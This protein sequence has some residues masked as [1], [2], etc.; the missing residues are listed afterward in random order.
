MLLSEQQQKLSG[1]RSL[2]IKVN[3]GFCSGCAG[4]T[5]S[6]S[7]GSCSSRLT[8]ADAQS[9]ADSLRARS[10]NERCAHSIHDHLRNRLSCVCLA[11]NKRCN[12]HCQ[13]KETRAVALTDRV[14]LDGTR[15]SYKDPHSVCVRGECEVGG[16]P[17]SQCDSSRCSGEINETF[18]PSGHRKWAAMV[19]SAPRSRRINVEY[20]E[21][22]TPAAKPSRTPS[23]G[24]PRSKVGLDD[25]ALN[26]APNTSAVL[27]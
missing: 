5:A 23:H 20:V 7:G 9:H 2:V 25:W 13:S 16:L 27:Q 3:R 26:A 22:T 17:V 12:L 21:E 6:V 15:C 4:R 18:H 19:C 10:D 24:R 1:S 11:A 8:Q 14:V